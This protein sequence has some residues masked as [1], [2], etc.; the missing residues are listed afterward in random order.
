MLL[1]LSPAQTYRRV[2]C[3]LPLMLPPTVVRVIVDV[4]L[5]SSESGRR[6]MMSR[7]MSQLPPLL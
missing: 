7:T 2:L 6:L 5:A 1:C 3:Q 4:L